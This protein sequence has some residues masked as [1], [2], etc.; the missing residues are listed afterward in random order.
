M[1]HLPY[2]AAK[3]VLFVVP[4]GERN[5]VTAGIESTLQ[6][7]LRWAHTAADKPEPSQSTLTELVS[8]HAPAADGKLQG[9]ACFSLRQSE[10]S[11]L[12]KHW[13]E[14]VKLAARAGII[15]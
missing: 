2:D 1:S 11:L 14:V 13:A 9:T 6:H 7:L 10:V 5:E 4:H 15:I 3:P 8:Q 12:T